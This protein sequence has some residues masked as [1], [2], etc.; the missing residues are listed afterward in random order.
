M[1]K[2]VHK[3]GALGYFR[4]GVILNTGLEFEVFKYIF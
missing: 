1:N 2:S 3:P 4:L